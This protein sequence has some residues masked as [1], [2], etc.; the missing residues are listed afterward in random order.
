[1]PSAMTRMEINVKPGERVRVRA[2]YRMSRRIVSSQLQLHV[3]RACSR[4]SEGLPKERMAAAR[5]SSGVRPRAIFSATCWSRWNCNSSSSRAVSAFRW[6]SDKTNIRNRA[7]MRICASWL[8]AVDDEVDCG[9]EPGPVFPLAI[10]LR[11]SGC[12][13]RI[14]LGGAASL[15]FAP[16][17]ANPPLL[18]KA[19]KR[20]VERTLLDLQNFIRYL[21]DALGDGPAMFGL[22]KDGF[23]YQQVESALHEI[24]RFTHTMI[25][26]TIDCR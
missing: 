15:G 1:M 9:G 21:L 10:E 20:G 22:K 16:F 26:Y 3:E 8:H 19:V 24:I 23:E 4:R 14:E 18:L 6:K 11:A 25:I 7:R 13:K 5:A 17:P 12:S 2:P